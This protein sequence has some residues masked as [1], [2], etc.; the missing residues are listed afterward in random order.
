MTTMIHLQIMVAA[1]CPYCQPAG[2]VA[3]VRLVVKVQ[4][5]LLQQWQH[6]QQWL[7][8]CDDSSSGCR[9]VMV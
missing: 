2:C 6:Q 1:A 5:Q 4:V 3:L 9:S 8:Q 7:P